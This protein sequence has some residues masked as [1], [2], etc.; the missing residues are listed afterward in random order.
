MI[1]DL[2]YELVGDNTSIYYNIVRSLTK[3]LL[4]GNEAKKNRGILFVGAPNSGKSTIA[5]YLASIFESYSL[6]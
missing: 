5:K 2:L 4:L 3:V 1:T 6:R